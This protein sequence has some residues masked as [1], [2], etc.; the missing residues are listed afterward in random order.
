MRHNNGAQF[1]AE[2]TQT[3]HRPWRLGVIFS[4][5]TRRVDAL[6]I[7]SKVFRAARTA[8]QKPGDFQ[9]TFTKKLREVTAMVK[10]LQLKAGPFKKSTLVI[11][12]WLAFFGSFFVTQPLWVASLQIAARVLP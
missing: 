5:C 6:S 7:K 10:Q 12:G 11:F 4:T 8:E 9:S 1:T 3:A 2:T